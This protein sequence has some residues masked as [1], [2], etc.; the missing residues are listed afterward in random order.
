MEE[1]A[2]FAGGVGRLEELGGRRAGSCES[3]AGSPTEAQHCLEEQPGTRD[4]GRDL[5]LEP[6]GHQGGCAVVV[7]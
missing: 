5:H 7:S 3:R 6:C 4:H 1:M 2:V